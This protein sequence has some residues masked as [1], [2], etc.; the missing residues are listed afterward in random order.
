MFNFS[1][2]KQVEKFKLHSLYF[3]LYDVY[4]SHSSSNEIFMIFYV[5]SKVSLGIKQVVIN[6]DLNLNFYLIKYSLYDSNLHVRRK[7]FGTE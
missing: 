3:L 2:I 4:I 1:R 6:T 5:N 7:V